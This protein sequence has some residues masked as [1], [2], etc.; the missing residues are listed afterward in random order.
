MAA[1][2]LSARL[3]Q[4]CDEI[5]ANYG[6]H[7]FEVEL[8]YLDR[9]LEAISTDRDL[10]TIVGKVVL[11]ARRGGWLPELLDWAAKEPYPG[12]AAVARSLRDELDGV[13]ASPAGG[14]D[15]WRAT[16]VAGR[17]FLGRPGLRS[18]MREF[19]GPEPGRVLVVTGEPGSGCSYTRH[20]VGHL[21]DEL[22]TF[23]AVLAELGGADSPAYIL[24]RIRLALGLPPP[25]I[26]P[27][28]GIADG[29][30]W[31]AG[32]LN[33]LAYDRS[34]PVAL[35]LDELDGAGRPEV[36]DMLVRLAALTDRVRGFGLILLGRTVP[37][38]DERRVLRETVTRPVTADIIDHLYEVAALTGFS[39]DPLA[40]NELAGW[41]LRDDDTMA[42]IDARARRV[43]A[44]VR[45]WARR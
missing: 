22:G 7:R 36:G 44:A 35:L 31:L 8:G 34:P 45:D 32:R 6:L 27:G 30:A 40:V 23:Q 38:P 41:V 9:N 16:L 29:V 21:A 3:R 24:E 11:A 37:L 42:G 28:G 10:P 43:G 17:P 33:R 15:P 14:R 13:F 4:L 19:A 2:Q 20:F 39:L 25:D 18:A 12:L 5:V 1:E 26:A